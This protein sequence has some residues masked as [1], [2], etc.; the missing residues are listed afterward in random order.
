ME[1]GM[2]KH[3]MD[4]SESTLSQAPQAKKRQLPK[5]TKHMKKVMQFARVKKKL[6]S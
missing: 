4:S 2:T 3:L 1:D 6:L 5:C